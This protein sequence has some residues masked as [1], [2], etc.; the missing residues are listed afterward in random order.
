MH[1]SPLALEVY[2]LKELRFKV[3]DKPKENS[4]ITGFDDVEIDVGVDIKINNDNPLRW[5]C[6]LLIKSKKDPQLNLPYT[7]KVKYVGF[8]EVSESFPSER[9]ELLVESN[10][11]AILYSAAREM[12]VSI[13]GR[14]LFPAILIPSL[15]FIPTSPE[16]SKSGN[17]TIKKLPDKVVQKKTTRAKKEV[18]HEQTP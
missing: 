16:G 15:T 2:Y 18:G 10:A 17:L 1:V 12:L 9:V 8:F 14:G 13:T 3:N 11:P 4:S 7:F 5:R 6:E